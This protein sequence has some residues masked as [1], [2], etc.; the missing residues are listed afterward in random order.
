VRL[1]AETDRID[2]ELQ[3]GRADAALVGE[4]KRLVLRDPYDERLRERLML[5]LYRSGR[6]AEALSAYHDARTTL[7]HNFGIE[8]SAR[9]RDLQRRILQ[10]DPTL[11][12]PCLDAASRPAPGTVGM[13]VPT[14]TAAT[15]TNTVAGVGT[16]PNCVSHVLGDFGWAVWF[17][18]EPDGSRTYIITD[19]RTG[20]V[21]RHGR[22]EHWDDVLLAAIS[23]LYPPSNEGLPG[24][25]RGPRPDSARPDAS[26]V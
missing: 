15:D 13:R 5:A 12:P 24:K 22:Q 10:H 11:D 25:R 26:P 4:I 9:L 21:I 8:P 7:V 2:A 17:T 18:N 20:D 14:A 16:A 6:Q 23:D 19:A 1:T 3:L